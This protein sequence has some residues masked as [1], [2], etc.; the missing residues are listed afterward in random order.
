MP[1]TW[2]Q[3]LIIGLALLLILLMAFCAY[4]CYQQMKPKVYAVDGA[5]DP[6]LRYNILFLGDGFKTAEELNTYR[7]AVDQLVEGLLLEEPFCHHKERLNFYRIDVRDPKGDLDEQH[8]PQ[9]TPELEPMHP[10]E[11][12]PSLSNTGIQVV[13]ELMVFQTPPEETAT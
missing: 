4:Y 11:Y 13:P 5:Y 1:T 3:W 9:N 10:M 12:E 2:K 6:H 8:C 7:A